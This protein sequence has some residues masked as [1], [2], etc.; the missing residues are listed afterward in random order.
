MPA[1]EKGCENVTDLRVVRPAI[2]LFQ[3]LLDLGLAYGCRLDDLDWART[4]QG[5]VGKTWSP[6]RKR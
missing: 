6:R 1:S 2:S 3:Q 4:Q 5:I